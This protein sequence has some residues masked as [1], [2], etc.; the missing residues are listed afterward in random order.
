MDIDPIKVLLVDDDEDEASATRTVAS[1]EAVALDRNIRSNF[2]ASMR[3]E[4]RTTMHGVIG[5]LDLLDETELTEKQKEYLKL[6]RHSADAMMGMLDRLSEYTSSNLIGT[7]TGRAVSGGQGKGA[8]SETGRQ[9]K[10]LL[11]DDSKVTRK[12]FTHLLEKHGHKVVAVIDGNEAVASYVK[13]PFDIVLMD[14]QMPQMSGLN[15]TKLIRAKEA[16]TGAHTPILALTAAETREEIERCLQSGMDGYLHK[17]ADAVELLENLARYITA[18]GASP[19][20]S[21]GSAMATVF[22]ELVAAFNLRNEEHFES[23][24]FRLKKLAAE[25]KLTKVADEILRIQLAFRSGAVEKVG[26]MLEMLKKSI[27]EK[28]EGERGFEL[29]MR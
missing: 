15:A 14:V 26:N 9:F 17:N 4:M 8:K 5:S 19:V 10:V 16:T 28:K 24:A 3:H 21:D 22:S 13:E 29:N 23:C 11:A 20:L 27:A 12:V 25:A 1:N 2:Y 18:P 7:D 6:A